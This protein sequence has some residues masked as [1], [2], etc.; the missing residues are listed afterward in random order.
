MTYKKPPS[1]LNLILAVAVF[2]ALLFGGPIIWQGWQDLTGTV[3][4]A[5]EFKP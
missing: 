2:F 3:K 1:P 4:T 5:Q